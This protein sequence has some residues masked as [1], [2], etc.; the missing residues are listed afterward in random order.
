M[1]SPEELASNMH[2]KSD[3]ERLEERWRRCQ[4]L[5]EGCPSPTRRRTNVRQEG[6]GCPHAQ[7][8]Q[9]LGPNAASHTP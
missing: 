5:P 9:Y 8:D 1:L 3:E 2:W 6:M 7:M 4:R